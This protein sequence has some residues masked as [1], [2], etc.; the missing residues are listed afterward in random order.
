MSDYGTVWIFIQRP[1]EHRPE[2]LTLDEYLNARGPHTRLKVTR[3]LR[4]MVEFHARRVG[5][6]D[7]RKVSE[8]ELDRMTKSL[9]RVKGKDDYGPDREAWDLVDDMKK[10]SYPFV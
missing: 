5:L 1:D 6:A 3:S 9:D 10:G 7:R 4:E 2:L 8:K